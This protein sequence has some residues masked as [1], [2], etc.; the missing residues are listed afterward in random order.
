VSSYFYAP[1]H[2]QA[3]YFYSRGEIFNLLNLEYTLTKSEG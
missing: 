2:L 1:I 3:V